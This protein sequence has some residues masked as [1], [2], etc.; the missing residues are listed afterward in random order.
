MAVLRPCLVR[1]A[2]LLSECCTFQDFICF[3]GI[4]EGDFFSGPACFYRNVLPCLSAWTPSMLA[5]ACTTC[6]GDCVIARWFKTKTHGTT[7]FHWFDT[8]FCF[9]LF[10]RYFWKRLRLRLWLDQLMVSVSASLRTRTRRS[11]SLIA[12]CRNGVRRLPAENRPSPGCQRLKPRQ[13]LAGHRLWTSRN[14]PRSNT[15]TKM[16][17]AHL[18]GRL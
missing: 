3:R 1:S 4:N 13:F 15:S 16:R 11:R 18:V 8:D 6:G 14:M 7:S 17:Q 2:R 9:R 10:W 12:D 5:V